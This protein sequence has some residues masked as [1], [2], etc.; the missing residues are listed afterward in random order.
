MNYRTLD[1]GQITRELF[2]TFERRQSVTKC[3]RRIDGQWV[4][5]DIPFTE[6]YTERWDDEDFSALVRCLQHTLSAGGTV[7]GAFDVSG[8]LKGFA[9][10][11]SGFFGTVYRYLDLSLLH[12][13]AEMR[14]NGIGGKLFAMAAEWAKAQGADRLYISSHCALETQAFYKAMGCVEAEE[15]NM[16]HVLLAPYDC[17]LELRL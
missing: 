3:W 1:C 11:E 15:Y 17:Q 5:R 12:V 9:A 10:V 4:V 8:Q 2:C 14:G 7:I 6:W 13:S 16:E